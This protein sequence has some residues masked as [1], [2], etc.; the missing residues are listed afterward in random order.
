MNA[1]PA[2]TMNNGLK[3]H[4]MGLGT[5]DLANCSESILESFKIGYR[6]LDTAHFYGNEKEVGKA[7][8]NSGLKREEIFVT[9]KLWPTDYAN[10]EKALNDMFKRFNLSYIDLVLL[11]WPFGDF[12]SAW[13]TLE[14]Y[15]KELLFDLTINEIKQKVGFVCNAENLKAFGPKKIE[16]ILPIKEEKRIT[17]LVVDLEMIIK[18]ALINNN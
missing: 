5:Y 13:K 7:V 18:K 17:I 9:S 12:I 14:K 6:H 11:H 3:I 2:L 16:D 4:Q 15:C 10:P 8:L 1:C